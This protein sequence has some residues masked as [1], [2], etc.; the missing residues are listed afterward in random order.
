MIECNLTGKLSHILLRKNA[1]KLFFFCFLNSTAKG[2]STLIIKISEYAHTTLGKK[3]QASFW[4][5]NGWRFLIFNTRKYLG[6][7]DIFIILH[8]VIVLW[9]HRSKLIKS[10]ISNI[11]SLLCFNYNFIQLLKVID[12]MIN[13]IF[14]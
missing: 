5:Q 2:L 13:L 11:F 4:L 10:G 8:M 9:I 6:V 7:M 1:K 3:S 14:E 12:I